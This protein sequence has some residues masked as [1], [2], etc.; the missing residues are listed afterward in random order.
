MPIQNCAISSI[1][2][3]QPAPNQWTRYHVLHLYKRM[4]F[5]ASEAEIQAGLQMT[6]TQLVD[7]LLDTAVA[8]PS[9][10]APY[11]ADFTDEDYDN[12]SETRFD[13][14]HQL[15]NRFLREM[16]TEG[17]RSKMALFWHGHFVTELDVYDC[18]S[19][20]WYYYK[21]LHDYAF[22]NFRTFVERMGVTPAMLVYL[23]GNVNVAEEPNENYARELLE[24]FTLGANNG[25]TSEDIINIARALTGW[26]VE[27]NDCLPVDPL[28]PMLP[29]VAAGYEY[30]DGIKTIFGQTGNWNY[31]DV[32][33]LI[34][35]ERQDEVALFICTKIYKFFV[36]EEVNPAIVNALADTFKNNNWEII[37]VL[38]Q[39]FKSEHFFDN[40]LIGGHI[41]SPTELFAGVAKAVEMQYPDDYN[42]DDLEEWIDFCDSLGQRLFEP[43]N[44]AGWEGYRSWINENTLSNRWA[45]MNEFLYNIPQEAKNRLRDTIQ[46]GVNFSADPEVITRYVVDLFV[47]RPLEEQHLQV[48]IQHLKAGFPDNYYEPDAPIQWTLYYEEAPDQIINL[49]AYLSRLP[50]F[51]MN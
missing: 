34:F 12:I 6:P 46:Q 3:F 37:P 26:R 21:L 18:S 19:Y 11:W 8:L 4:S 30:D 14:F 42:E 22:G 39:L 13:H 40:T 33:Q 32:H 43:P 29:T 9:P 35:T 41:K 48:A 28:Y 31:N 5:G 45:R 7:L 44:V 27:Q 25:Y 20:L 36:H 16:I 2:P 47:N 24:L 51:Q 50:E 38:K 23:N 15:E 49:L 1:S 17:V 10:A